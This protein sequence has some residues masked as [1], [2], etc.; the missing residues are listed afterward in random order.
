M[1]FDVVSIC[2]LQNKSTCLAFIGQCF[3][4]KFMKIDFCSYLRS[5]MVDEFLRGL[6]NPPC[7]SAS[8]I[9]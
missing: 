9:F 3:S 2:D 8:L 5:D 1:R 7:K 4:G 6:E